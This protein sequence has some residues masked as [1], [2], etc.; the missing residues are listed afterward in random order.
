MSPEY[1]TMSNLYST[2]AIFEEYFSHYPNA[3]RP[4]HYFHEIYFKDKKNLSD[5][6]YSLDKHPDFE[7]FVLIKNAIELEIKNK[8]HFDWTNLNEKFAYRRMLKGVYKELINIGN[9]Y[10]LVRSDIARQSLKRKDQLYLETI[11]IYDGEILLPINQGLDFRIGN[12]SGECFGYVS[13]WALTLLNQKRPFGI[14]PNATPYLKPVNFDSPVGRK[15]PD[16]NHV[17]V[18]N[19]TISEYQKHQNRLNDYLLKHKTNLK[20]DLSERHVIHKFLRPHKLAN[21]MIQKCDEKRDE[22]YYL[23]F[24]GYLCGHATAFCKI[25]Q[26]Y[27]FF[28]CNSGWYRFKD[29]ED[30]KEWLPFYIK[31][32]GYDR[33]YLEHEIMTLKNKRPDSDL[34]LPVMFAVTVILMPIIIPTLVFE[35]SYMLVAR[36][37]IYAGFHAKNLL[38]RIGGYFFNNEKTDTLKPSVPEPSVYPVSAYLDVRMPEQKTVTK[39]SSHS[40]HM[41]SKYLDV[42]IDN[43]EKISPDLQIKRP[44]LISKY[45]DVQLQNAVH[46]KPSSN[47]VLF[48]RSKSMTALTVNEPFE[49]HQSRENKM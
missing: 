38:E 36:A 48:R 17:G 2:Y 22:V 3:K 40:Y 5:L 23:I 4:K 26:K 13:Y 8:D 34:P 1:E 21:E 39:P 19:Q 18:L 14:N 37:F 16:L 43:N 12:S 32:M 29:A 15:H 10:S 6:L 27:H 33:N 47:S 31:K 30:F 20:G 41:I 25:D 9:T 7:M 42:A 45:L 11:D 44:H 49:I 28:D 35:L 46:K 24:H